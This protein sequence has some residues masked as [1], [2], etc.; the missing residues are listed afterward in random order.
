MS[1]FVYCMI[2]EGIPDYIKVG[3]S[4]NINNRIIAL[5]TGVPFNFEC[6][7]Y[8][9]IQKELMANTEK[10]IHKD[11]VDA[12][13]E[14]KKEFFKCNPE[15]IIYIF[16]KYG[17][18][19]Y[20]KLNQNDTIVSKCKITNKNNE[21]KEII[22]SKYKTADKNNDKYKRYLISKY[23][24][25]N[26]EKNIY[27]NFKFNC[28]C[29]NYSTNIKCNYLKHIK[30]YLH[31]EKEYNDKLLICGECDKKFVYEAAYNNHVEK[32]HKKNETKILDTE[33]KILLLEQENK[34]LKENSELNKEILITHDKYIEYIQQINKYKK[35]K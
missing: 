1:G 20:D 13:F 34:F 35:I 23:Y 7:F 10:K 21:Q 12:G 33:M 6:K 3:F 16:E 28:I 2:S 26:T 30:S 14:K 9:E 19:I 22:A 31:T 5:S 24:M 32:Y 18:I 25:K 4:L 29:C 27:D 15:D 11:I 8:I 17:I